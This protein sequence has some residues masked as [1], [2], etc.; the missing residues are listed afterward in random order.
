MSVDEQGIPD[1]LARNAAEAEL[2][3]RLSPGDLII[4]AWGEKLAVQRTLGK[5]RTDLAQLSGIFESGKPGEMTMHTD[6]TN[7]AKFFVL[8][9]YLVEISFLYS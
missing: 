1:S 5:V 6:A 3:A 9:E 7:G 2:K 8:V 4:V